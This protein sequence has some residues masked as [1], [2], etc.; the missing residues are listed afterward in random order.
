[1]SI[2]DFPLPAKLPV[3]QDDGAADHLPGSALPDLALPA[4]DGTNV[5]LAALRGRWVIY[6]YPMTGRPGVAL[7][8]GWDGIPGARGCTPQSCSFRDHFAE[9]AALETGVYGLST[10]TGA[11]QREARERLHLPFQLLSDD[12][13]QLKRHL[14]L[15]TF[16]VAGMELYKRLTLIVRDGQI[17]KVFYP[18]FPPDRNA[19]EVLAWLRRPH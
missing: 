13:L 10:Q 5:R 19:D 2:S 8:E 16:T 4:T 3:P 14:Q 1:M 17:A 7:P 12:T 9:L 18:V 6:V 11:D 15:P